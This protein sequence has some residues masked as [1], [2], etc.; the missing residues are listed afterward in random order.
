MFD[1]ILAGKPNGVQLAGDILEVYWGSAAFFVLVA[2]FLWKGLPS[3]KASLKKR[4]ESIRSELQDAHDER[5]AAE[6]ALEAGNSVLPDLGQERSRIRKEAVESSAKL[7]ADLIERAHADA[8]ALVE[9]GKSDCLAMRRQAMADIEAEIAQV[10]KQT[11]E[12]V[13]LNDIDAAAQTDLIESYIQK[14]GQLV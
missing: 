12:A 4:T 5:L 7:K 6:Q 8:A 10:T 1:L 2:L 13:V 11:T 14:V 3:L 9:K